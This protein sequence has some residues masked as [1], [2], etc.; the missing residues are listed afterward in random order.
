MAFTFAN[1]GLYTLAGDDYV[2][3]LRHGAPPQDLLPYTELVRF[4]DVVERSDDELRAAVRPLLADQL[5]RAPGTNQI[6]SVWIDAPSPTARQLSNRFWT[7]G[8]TDP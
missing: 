6:G 3:V 8:Y 7:A 5:H 2:G 1:R 4:D